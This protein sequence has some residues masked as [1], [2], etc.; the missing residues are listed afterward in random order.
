MSEV[1]LDFSKLNLMVV[2]EAGLDVYTYGLSTRQSPEADCPVVLVHEV[3]EYAGMAAN[4]AN[5]VVALGAKARLFT[6]NPPYKLFAATKCDVTFTMAKKQEIIKHRL[7]SNSVQIARIDYED[8]QPLSD[9]EEKS[10]LELICSSVGQF[11]AVLLQDYGKGVW[12]TSLLTQFIKFCSSLGKK[13]FVDPFVGRDVLDYSGCYLIKPNMAEAQGLVG[14]ISPKLLA[15]ALTN[16][17]SACIAAITLGASGIQANDDHYPA[18]PTAAIDV[19]GAGDTVMAV[20]ACSLLSGNTLE[21]S[22]KLANK[23]ASIV[24][25]KQGPAQVSVEELK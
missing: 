10:F 23:A 24:I 14:E 2:G 3:H 9:V 5:N 21:D 15:A 16:A 4:L 22:A 12:S 1:N 25:Q 7:I 6:I 20:L 19:S 13:V 17:T 18:V 11:D 8:V